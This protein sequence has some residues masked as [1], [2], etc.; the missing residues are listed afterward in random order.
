M[1]AVRGI[2]VNAWLLPFAFLPSYPTSTLAPILVPF[3]KE[4]EVSEIPELVHARGERLLRG[5]AP[6]SAP[7]REGRSAACLRCHGGEAL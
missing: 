6:A 1:K 7:L 2:T 5:T 3:D 4:E